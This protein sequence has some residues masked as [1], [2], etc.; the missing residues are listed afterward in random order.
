MKRLIIFLILILAVATQAY[1]FGHHGG[2][3]NPPATGAAIR[4]IP[5]GN[6]TNGS[7]NN[8]VSVPEPA[9]L[10]LLGVGLIGLYWLS[11]KLKKN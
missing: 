9:T 5:D 8:S 2:Y 10:L 7:D 3:S 11:R 6:S 1:G 4:V